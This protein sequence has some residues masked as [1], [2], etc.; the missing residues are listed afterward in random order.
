M[1]FAGCGVCIRVRVIVRTHQSTRKFESRG[2]SRTI[3]VLDS[4]GG[5]NIS[6][7]TQDLSISTTDLFDAESFVNLLTKLR[8]DSRPKFMRSGCPFSPDLTPAKYSLIRA[9]WERWWWWC[10]HICRPSA[11]TR[12]KCVKFDVKVEIDLD[13]RR[14]TVVQKANFQPTMHSSSTY[15]TD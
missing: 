4:H 9:L 7:L 8:H 15:H 14:W 3:Y 11:T 1:L 2:V 6:G 10:I 13:R 5:L 12:S